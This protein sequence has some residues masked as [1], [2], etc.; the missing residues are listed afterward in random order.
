MTTQLDRRTLL[1]W[2]AGGSAAAVFGIPLPTLAAA[3]KGGV[4]VIGTTQKPR[5]LNSAVQSGIATMSPAAQIFASPLLMDKNWKPQP[6]LADKWEVSEDGRSVRLWLNKN[7]TFHD[8]KPVTGEDV[9]YS[10]E[11]VRDNHPFKTML[12]PVNAVT[13]EDTHI[14]TVRLSE[15]H[16]ALL[17]AMS[18]SF[19]PIIPK[20]VFGDGQD[21]KSHPM[22]N[23]P[24]GS[25]PFKVVEF[26]PGEHTILE[27]YDGFFMKDM[28][29]LDRII[30]KVMKDPASLML[31]LEKG[32]IDI[33][34]EMNGSQ[35]IKRAATLSNVN[36]VKGAAP[37]I[38]PLIWIALNTANEKF[39]D[40]RVRQAINYALDKDFITKTLLGGV[41]ARATG[42]IVKAS[43]FYNPAV[44]TYPLNLKKA[45]ALL[46]EAGLKK[47]AD[48]TRLSF[49][50]DVVPGS[51]ELKIV[52]EYM[53]PA[54]KKVGIVA[55]LRQS[56]DFP[57]WA[58]RVSSLEFEC[59]IDSVWNWG[60]PV[61]GV[62]RTWLSD[63]IRKG[64]IWSNTQ[65]YRN[66]RVDEL[67]AS[68]AREGDEQ[69]RKA[70]YHEVQSIIVDD[71]PCIFVFE[72]TFHYGIARQVAGAPDNI[73]GLVSPAL[74]MHRTA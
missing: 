36:V 67:L 23:T 59:T 3:A 34:M 8:G 18:T 7:A 28:P 9:A 5:H 71:C 74:D 41:H 33:H 54:M 35:D 19:L 68:A 57:T 13:V 16:P 66:P 10:I 42:P 14:V 70:L 49:E 32:E 20:H 45:E 55:K 60:D 69:K 72:L 38:G 64:V 51:Q 24:V 4:V 52:Q 62:H 17:L 63:N 37:A 1:Q 21:I 50:V 65:S 26:K 39:A 29:R 73:W 48:G 6:Y 31:A 47:Q 2:A 15:S 58:K 30:Y 56:P 11:V 22:N 61:I 27:R 44:Q 43:P 40:K 46:D 25:G 12:G 53:V